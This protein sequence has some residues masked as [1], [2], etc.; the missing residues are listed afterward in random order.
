M[1]TLCALALASLFLACPGGRGGDAAKNSPS[2]TST[3]VV[4]PQAVP[5]KSTAM[6]PVFEPNK[7]TPT[8]RH[9]VATPSVS[10]QLLEYEIRM[11]DTIPAGPQTLSIV[12]GGK[13][14]H[15]LAITGNGFS[16]QLPTELMRGDATTMEVNLRPGTYTVSCPIHARRGMKRSVIVK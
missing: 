9:P 5:E 16:Q 13:E 14:A 11:P 2:K 6:N 1:R 3:N 8:K 4:N 12:N 10:V 7:E 15:G